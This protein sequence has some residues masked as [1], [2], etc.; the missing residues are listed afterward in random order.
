MKVVLTKGKV[1]L[2]NLAGDEAILAAMLANEEL[3]NKRYEKAVKA[4]SLDAATRKVVESNL[5]DE[6]RHREWLKTRVNA[7]K[8]H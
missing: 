4:K 5:R 8:S 3:T 1:V 7:K 2:A 6:R